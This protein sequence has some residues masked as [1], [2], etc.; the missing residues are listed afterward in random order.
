MFAS[1]AAF[2]RLGA[3][4]WFNI[5]KETDWLAT[6]PRQVAAAFQPR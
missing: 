1:A 3:V 6:E 5:N 2:P 4:L